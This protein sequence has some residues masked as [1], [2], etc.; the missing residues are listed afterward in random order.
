MRDL[1]RNF[2]TAW[3][4]PRWRWALVAAVLSDILGFGVAL[5]PPAQWILDA[6]TAVVLFALLRFRWPLLPA[7]AIE[8]VPGL[9]LFPAWTLVVAALASTENPKPALSDEK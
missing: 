9:Q 6:I 3:R 2:L 8:V 5:W 7:L 4:L 1:I